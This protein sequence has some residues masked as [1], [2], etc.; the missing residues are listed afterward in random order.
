MLILTYLS[1][2]GY[3]GVLITTRC[4]GFLFNWVLTNDPYS[5]FLS[6]FYACYWTIMWT[7]VVQITTSVAGKSIYGK[8]KHNDSETKENP[9]FDRPSC[10][11]VSPCLRGEELQLS[12]FWRTESGCPYWLPF[13]VLCKPKCWEAFTSWQGAVGELWEFVCIWG[14][15]DKI[16]GRFGFLG[17]ITIRSSTVREHKSMDPLCIMFRI[18]HATLIH[19]ATKGSPEQ[20]IWVRAVVLSWQCTT[21]CAM[22]SCSDQS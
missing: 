22:Q 5:S 2:K 9:C 20:V 1:F 16:V 3:S 19:V 17:F 15:S 14:T 6:T 13:A 11:P 8:N 4:L 10:P 7:F 12:Y 18:S 21:A